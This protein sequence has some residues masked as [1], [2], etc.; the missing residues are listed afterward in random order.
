MCGRIE[1]GTE[2]RKCC[3]RFCLSKPYLGGIFAFVFVLLIVVYDL[4]SSRRVHR[5][6]VWDRGI[7]GDRSEPSC[8]HRQSGIWHAFAGWAL[9]LTRVSHP[10]T[11]WEL[12]KI[13][14]I[15]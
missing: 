7:G 1:T 15:S 9:A 6:T 14:Q 3:F 10:V 2:S 13:S 12:G 5:A 8:S 11:K 4:G